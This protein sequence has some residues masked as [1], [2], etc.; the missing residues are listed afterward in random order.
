MPAMLIQSVAVL[1][2]VASFLVDK[3]FL[4]ENICEEV[5]A[6]LAAVAVYGPCIEPHEW[7][8]IMCFIPSVNDGLLKIDDE[9]R[10]EYGFEPRPA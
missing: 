6:T 3:E 1:T 8:S 10:K 2:A 4:A 5:S 7:Y 9:Q